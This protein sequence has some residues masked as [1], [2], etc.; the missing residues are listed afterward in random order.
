MLYDVVSA[1]YMGQYKL[2]IEFENGHIGIVDFSDYPQRGG[3]F[4]KFKDLNFFRKYTVSK[5]LGTI[6][7]N[8]EVDIAPETLYKKSASA[9][10][11][12][13]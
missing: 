6:V 12:D 3:V 8:N 10:S 2:K 7:W 1:E 13:S 4:E 11:P 9:V 5:E